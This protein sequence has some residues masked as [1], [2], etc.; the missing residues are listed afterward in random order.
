MLALIGPNPR[1]IAD[2]VWAK[3]MWAG[4]NLTVDDL[5]KKGDIHRVPF[6]S[7][8]Y[9]IEMTRALVITWLFA[10]LRR[11]ESDQRHEL[12]PSHKHVQYECRFCSRSFR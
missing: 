8:A 11:N 10:G 9:P 3:L 5:P 4:L 1:A 6:P 7:T 12:R 2:D